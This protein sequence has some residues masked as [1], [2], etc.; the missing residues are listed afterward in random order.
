VTSSPI[1][2][3]N[4]GSSV[5]IFLDHYVAAQLGPD[6]GNV[7]VSVNDG[8]FEVVPASA[9][10]FNAP[11]VTLTGGGKNG[12]SGW[13]GS[14]T[15]RL[16]GSWATSAADLSGLVA[17]GDT[18]KIRFEFGQDCAVAWLGWLVDDVL[19]VACPPVPAP[20]LSLGADYED[21]DTD[22]T[23]TLQWDRP[24][25]ATGPDELQL[26]SVLP[27]LLADDAESGMGNWTV[28]TSD[29]AVGWATT[30][31]K[32]GHPGNTFTAI[33]NEAGLSGSAIMTTATPL[34]L[35]EGT[36]T[37]RFK[38]HFVSENSDQIAVEVSEDGA[39][40]TPIYTQLGA[41]ELPPDQVTSLAQDELVQREFDLSAY[42]GSPL[43]LRFRYTHG[44]P[45]WIDVLRLGWFVDDIEVTAIS[46]ADVAISGTSHTMTGI[47]SG[48]YLAR[49]RTT[50]TF[51]SD[52][53][54]G[55]WSDPL[56]IS[57][58]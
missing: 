37:L 6:G 26:A 20:A 49:V 10:T 27:P 46:W 29:F 40:W 48:G 25:A 9:F 35:P 7:M 38:D 53:A 11:N 42:G 41:N 4:D 57:V 21:P 13:S 31:L 43:H 14:D 45:L 5:R 12:Q 54:P 39:S 17:P 30:P 16:R 8:E 23:F 1:V 58:A 22:G 51:G 32:P 55:D 19:V 33:P 2:A 47:P 44:A 15:Q 50:Y 18:F 52:T 36:V 24:D 56:P 3:P 34:A 28:T